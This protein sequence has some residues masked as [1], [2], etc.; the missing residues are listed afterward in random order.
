MKLLLI[1]LLL[2]IIIQTSWG[3]T[4]IKE[5]NLYFEYSSNGYEHNIVNPDTLNCIQS[6]D[7]TSIIKYAN[8]LNKEI[9]RFRRCLYE[10][11]TV[12]EIDS[13]TNKSITVVRREFVTY[14]FGKWEFYDSTGTQ[15]N[16]VHYYNGDALLFTTS[17]SKSDTVRIT[18]DSINIRVLSHETTYRYVI[19]RAKNN[20]HLKLQFVP[21]YNHNVWFI[22]KRKETLESLY[23]MNGRQKPVDRF[24]IMDHPSKNRRSYSDFG[25]LTNGIYYV[26]YMNLSRPMY[27]QEIVLMD[28]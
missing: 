28:D 8:G 7:S 22:Y 26:Y 4:P 2:L 14:A 23:R 18:Q 17:T 10:Q 25:K 15:T 21:R 19:R 13:I 24:E 5:E 3:Q 20:K 16:I 27:M 9:Q 6:F 11:D 12:I 1:P